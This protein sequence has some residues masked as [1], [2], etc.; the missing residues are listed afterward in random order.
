MK[1]LASLKLGD[2]QSKISLTETFRQGLEASGT[3]PCS[4]SSERTDHIDSRLH[5]IRDGSKAPSVLGAYLACVGRQYHP[6]P[7]VSWHS[8]TH[9]ATRRVEKGNTA[10]TIRSDGKT[11]C[12]H[13]QRRQIEQTWEAKQ[14]NTVDRNSQC[15]SH[16]AQKPRRRSLP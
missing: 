3:D 15:L 13:S 10:T 4:R 8:K 5:P 2:R 14:L 1:P 16:R 11:L 9:R 6:W 7:A 12:F